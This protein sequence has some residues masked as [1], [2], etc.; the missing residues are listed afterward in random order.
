MMDV[1]ANIHEISYQPLSPEEIRLVTLQPHDTTD[2]IACKIEHTS[3]SVSDQDLKYEALSYT[4]GSPH[5]FRTISL[6]GRTCEVRENLWWALYHLRLED[7][8]R[9]LWIDALCINQ[10]DIAEKSYQVSQMDRIYKRAIRVAIW[11]GREEKEDANALQ[12]LEEIHSNGGLP[13]YFHFEYER[14]THSFDPVANEEWYRQHRSMW[15]PISRLCARVY[16]TRV[17]IIQEVQLATKATLYC[18]NDAIDWEIFS[19][20]LYSA[21]NI[22]YHGDAEEEDIRRQLIGSHASRMYRQKLQNA[23]Q[24]SPESNS[25]LALFCNHRNSQCFQLQDRVFGLHS[26]A[27]DCCRKA[28]P[29]D[30]AKSLQ[31]LCVQLLEH[32]L[33]HD[34]EAKDMLQAYQLAQELLVSEA[35][36]EF[37]TYVTSRTPKPFQAKG[38]GIDVVCYVSPSLGS[39]PDSYIE[40]I[41]NGDLELY[42]P[43]GL[44]SCINELQDRRRK[45]DVLN[46]VGNAQ[47]VSSRVFLKNPSTIPLLFKPFQ[48]TKKEKQNISEIRQLPRYKDILASVAHLLRDGAEKARASSTN[49]DCRLFFT[50]HGMIGFAPCSIREGDLLCL[51][52]GSTMFVFIRRAPD[53]RSLSMVG[54][55]V[56]YLAG[57]RFKGKSKENHPKL[58]FRFDFLSLILLTRPE[59]VAE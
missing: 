2:T 36:E 44:M 27:Y 15:K 56:V 49:A 57:L 21:V 1:T 45:G 10:A 32:S 17:W 38:Q 13:E 29:V 37:Q 12:Y 4:W 53:D 41:L 46:D 11:L 48:E 58:H 28:V 33:C 19:R 7:E 52:E 35:S 31:L 22:D 24:G 5:E 40:G 6:N 39:L 25:L 42:L 26:L 55:P 47:A 30:Y 54:R 14:P 9:H 23:I 16:W 43:N 34:F 20:V 18:G 50:S 51:I 3:F 8:V 59:A